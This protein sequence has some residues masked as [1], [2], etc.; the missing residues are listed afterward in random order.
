MIQNKKILAIDSGNSR[1]KW[2]ADFKVS[3]KSTGSVSIKEIPDLNNKWKSFEKP[4]ICIIANVAGPKVGK[5]LS[6]ICKNLWGCDPV[7]VMGSLQ[8]CGVTNCYKD[9]EALGAD[10]W[11]ALIATHDLAIG[12]C[13][14]VSLGTAST[15]DMLYEGGRFVGGIIMPG[16]DLMTSSL[17]NK[18][19]ALSDTAGSV[20]AFPQKT[21]DAITTGIY[22]ATVG[23]INEMISQ[24]MLDRK[25]RPKIVLSGGNASRVVNQF[26]DNSVVRKN[27]V[28]DGLII[29]GKKLI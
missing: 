14:V 25:S 10:R 8:C 27:L 15:I 29:I 2:K 28:I 17:S 13:L 19:Y 23:A 24:M 18:T 21:I 16:F 22:R 11:A 1:L 3:D 5:A 12:D 7:F 20:S 26:P 6:L 9:P 4:D